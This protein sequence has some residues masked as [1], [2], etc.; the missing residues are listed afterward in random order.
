MSVTVWQC[1]S[2]KDWQCDC[3]TVWHCDSVT[4]EQCDSVAEWQCDSVTAAAFPPLTCTVYRPGPPCRGPLLPAG[5]T[6][7]LTPPLAARA[8]QPSCSVLSLQYEGKVFFFF[9]L[10]KTPSL[11]WCLCYT[12][13]QVSVL[14]QCVSDRWLSMS[15]WRR[16][17]SDTNPATV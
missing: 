10:Q 8:G 6:P 5:T 3:V 11:W 9:F 1:D 7:A 12:C 15:T 13:P 16:F 4:V 14:C 2:V 17:P